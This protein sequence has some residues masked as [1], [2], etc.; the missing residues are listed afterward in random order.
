M[1]NLFVF[2]V[3]AVISLGSQAIASQAAALSFKNDSNRT[4]SVRIGNEKDKIIAPSKS[5]QVESKKMSLPFV[6]EILDKE[7]GTLDTGD[8]VWKKFTVV[9]TTGKKTDISKLPSTFTIKQQEAT[10][11]ILL[12]TN[13]ASIFKI[14]STKNTQK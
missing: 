13:A 10:G 4:Y 9:S 6:V 12:L 7:S 11:K 5:S 3:L 14:E 1:K 8:D 2:S